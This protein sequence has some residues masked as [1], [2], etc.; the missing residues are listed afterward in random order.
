MNGRVSWC[1]ALVA[2][3]G[4]AAAVEGPGAGAREGDGSTTKDEAAEATFTGKADWS[5]DVCERRG[6]YGDGECD[7]FCPRRDQDCDPEPLGPEPQGAATRYPIVLA[8]GFDASPT[9]RWGFRGVAEA[10]RADG[11][12]VSVATVPPYNSPEVRGRYLAAEIDDALE[13]TGADRVNVIAHSMGGLDA[14]HAIGSL[15]YGDRVASLTTIASPHRG[16]H[17]ADVF[18][19]VLDGVERLAPGDDRW[20]GQLL[21]GAV[22]LWGRTFSELADDTDF[23]A[24]LE[25][26]SEANAERFAADNPD[27]PRVHYQSWAGVSSIFGRLGRGGHGEACGDAYLHHD[28]TTDVLD[29]TLLPF[30]WF[31]GHGLAL[32]ANDGMATVESARWGEFRGCIPADHLDEVGQVGDEGPDR[33]TGFDHLRFYR[34][35]AFD[36]AADGF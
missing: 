29:A 13:L 25:G 16:S 6:W 26:I 3:V 14:R 20:L 30:G 28:G 27:D 33:H 23:R 35:V 17:V 24:A 32:D 36:L 10:L 11:H 2:L 8:H 15:G 22:T 7:W 21:D 4:C 34:N 12:Q 31:T 9:N 18:L 19:G 5:F 1:A